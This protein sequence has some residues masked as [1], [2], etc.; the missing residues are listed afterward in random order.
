MITTLTCVVKHLD[1]LESALLASGCLLIRVKND[2]LQT[3]YTV[4]LEGNYKQVK[5]FLTIAA[6]DDALY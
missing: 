1:W 2:M 4:Q 6:N 3:G 5:E